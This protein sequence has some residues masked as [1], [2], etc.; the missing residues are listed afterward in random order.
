VGT[1]PDGTPLAFNAGYYSDAGL[2][3]L[4]NRTQCR[5]WRKSEPGMHSPVADGPRGRAVI[6]NANAF[7]T[8]VDGYVYVLSG[9]AIGRID[10]RSGE[11]S[12]WLQ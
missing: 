6:Q 2:V 10:P 3:M 8:A 9:N 5:C 11:V 1:G 12:T 4:D 7:C